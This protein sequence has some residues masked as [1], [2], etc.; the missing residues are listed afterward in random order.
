MPQGTQL[1]PRTQ[2]EDSQLQ[3]RE[4]PRQ[5]PALALF[6]GRANPNWPKADSPASP[7]PISPTLIL[8]A[9]STF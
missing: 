1:R 6:P 8:A 9:L 7:D 3:V 2:L 5:L 4:Q